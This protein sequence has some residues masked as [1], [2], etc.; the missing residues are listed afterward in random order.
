MFF[1]RV[2]TFLRRYGRA[3]SHPAPS[4]STFAEPKAAAAGAAV[5]P[6]V[7]TGSRARGFYFEEFTVG[8]VF[9]SRGRT[10]T[11]TDI[12]LFAGLTG[13]YNP[14]HTDSEYAAASR[15]GGRIMHGLCGLSIATGLFSRLGVIEGTTES[16]LSVETH[17]HDVMRIGDTIRVVTRVTRK[18]DL[19]GQNAGVVAFEAL[20]YNQ[21]DHLVQRGTWAA[22]IR[23]APSDDLTVQSNGHSTPASAA[24]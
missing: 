17:F 7:H 3:E 8:Q 4:L 13:D 1:D 2:A 20:T 15:W 18:R 5:N 9:E 14:L 12:Q 6:Y 23:K 21:Y 22:I 24:G 16:F 11:E 19:T 10:L